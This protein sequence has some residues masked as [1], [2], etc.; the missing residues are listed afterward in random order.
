M[1][2]WERED[3]FKCCCW[4]SSFC[5]ASLS[6]PQWHISLQ[7]ISGQKNQYQLQSKIVELEFTQLL[8]EF[9]GGKQLK[10]TVDITKAT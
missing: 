4:Q 5:A 10:A 2:F 6:L 1:H 8:D 7:Q 3:Q 9:L